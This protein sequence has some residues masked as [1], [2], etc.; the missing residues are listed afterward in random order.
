MKAIAETA[1]VEPPMGPSTV[2]GSL[3]RLVDRGL[4]RVLPSRGAGRKRYAMTRAGHQA[5]WAE[6]SRIVGLAAM[7]EERGLTTRM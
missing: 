3:A 6:S 2:Y 5:L 1:R 4:V 7:L